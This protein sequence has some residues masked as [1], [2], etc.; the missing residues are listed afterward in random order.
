LATRTEPVAA[1]EKRCG[2]LVAEGAPRFG[3]GTAVKLK[4]T[5]ETTPDEDV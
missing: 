4:L 3:A 1:A 5:P 2:Q